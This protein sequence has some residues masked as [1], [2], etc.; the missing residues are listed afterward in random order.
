MQATKNRFA[1][2]LAFV[3]DRPMNW[4]VFLQR[5][6]CT[7]DVVIIVDVVVQH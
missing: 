4:R 7:A 6:V 5:H 1:G 3:L 2:N